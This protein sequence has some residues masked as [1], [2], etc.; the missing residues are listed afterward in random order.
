LHTGDW[1]LGKN[2]EGQSRMDE[3][4]EFLKDFVKIVEENNIDLVIIAGD[5]YDTS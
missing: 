3:Q 5:V 2:L 1:H 4:E